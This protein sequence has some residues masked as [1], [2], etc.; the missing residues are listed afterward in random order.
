MRT[1]VPPG[2]GVA[3]PVVVGG[4][5]VLDVEGT[6]VEVPVGGLI[7]AVGVVVVVGFVVIGVG[8][9]PGSPGR[10]FVV[11]EVGLVNGPVVV[12]V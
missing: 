10:L 2:E 8:L 6:V 7:S 12:V 5:V 4:V 3:V 1:V 9:G 11:V